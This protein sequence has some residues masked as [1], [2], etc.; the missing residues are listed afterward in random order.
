MK[1]KQDILKRFKLEGIP[2][3]IARNLNLVSSTVRNI[4]NR[5]PDQ[6]KEF[7]KNIMPSQSVQN[8]KVRRHL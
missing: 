5:D 1:V 8:I 3:D 4:C 7:T 2:V 6:I